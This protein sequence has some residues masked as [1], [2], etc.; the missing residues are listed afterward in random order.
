MPL[1]FI[2]L[3]T[4]APLKIFLT[5]IVVGVLLWLVTSFI[6]MHPTIK[7]FLIAVVIIWLVVWILQATGLWKYLFS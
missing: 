4:T 7:K 6:P 3:A 2:L 5:I 1:L